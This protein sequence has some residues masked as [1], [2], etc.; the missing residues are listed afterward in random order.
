M[1]DKITATL[2]INPEDLLITLNEKL[3]ECTNAVFFGINALEITKE[4]PEKINTQENPIFEHT[5]TR[6]YSLKQSKENFS[7]WIIK[8]GFEDLIVALTELLISFSF[9]I[10]LNEKINANPLTTIENFR[11]LIFK[12]NDKNSLENFPNLLNKVVGSL[13]SPLKYTNEIN[14]INR[15]RRCLVHRNGVVKSVDFNNDAKN[16]IEL[17]WWFYE[18]ILINNGEKKVME[19][20]D[21]ITS[22]TKIEITEIVR[23]KSFKENEKIEI[24]LQEFNE[25]VLLCQRFGIEVRENFKLNNT[26]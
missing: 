25:L 14:S 2:R 26:Q 9:I 15:V 8:K 7:N 23:T 6:K 12:P 21:I 11:K 13:K 16:C 20:F 22:E 5:P 3:S 10:D 18:I 19:K 1:S 24:T 4:L 17:K